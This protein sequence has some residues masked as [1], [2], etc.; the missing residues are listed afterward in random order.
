MQLKTIKKTLKINK[1]WKNYCIFYKIKDFFIKKNS[2]KR[3]F[4]IQNLCIIYAYNLYYAKRL[5]FTLIF[6]TVLYCIISLNIFANKKTTEKPPLCLVFFKKNFVTF[7]LNTK[8]NANQTFL[9][10]L[11]CFWKNKVARLTG[12]K[13]KKHGKPCFFCFWLTAVA[14]VLWVI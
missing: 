5:R 1:K 13:Q 4:F 11:R 6:A 9:L 14:T 8:N 7:I 12:T 3:Y 10:N 2:I